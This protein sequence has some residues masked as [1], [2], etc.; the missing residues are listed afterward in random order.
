ME[1]EFFK[2]G[3]VIDT[4]PQVEKDKDYKFEEV[5][6]SADPVNWVMKSPDQWRKFPIFNQNGSGSCVAQTE[7]KELGIMRS[8]L[9]GVYV[10]FSAT[11][12]YQQRAN[13]PEGGM[14]AADAR[15]IVIKGGA[16]LEALTP[17]QSMTDS[18]MDGAIVE[19]YKKDVAA[20]FK[21]SN[22]VELPARDID[23]VASV[24]QR[25]QKGVMTWFYFEYAEWDNRPH[26]LNQNL[27][28]NAQSTCRHSITAVDFTL[29]PDGKKAIIIE[30]SWGPGAGMGGQRVIDEE[31]WRS[32]NW[33]ASYLLNFKFAVGET[34][35]PP[36]NLTKTLKFGMKDPEV[37]NLQDILRFLGFYPQNAQST[38]YLGAVTKKGVTDFQKAKGLVPDGVVGPITRGMLKSALAEA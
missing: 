13:R 38:G 16:T 12:I 3:A 7:A 32:R 31:M 1:S 36:F 30:D 34:Q 11:H 9:D 35:K 17:S 23:T 28:L 27:Q 24:I 18:Q 5:V 21:V 8:L 19:Q 10:H 2:Q 4:R 15:N 14:N 25:T 6:A 20:V 26:V 37:V 29:L 22:Y 33:Y